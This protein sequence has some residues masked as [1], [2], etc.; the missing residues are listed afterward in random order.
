MDRRDR[1]TEHI[2]LPTAAALVYFGV[3]AKQIAGSLE[4]RGILCD[5]AHALSM[6][7][8]I[9][10]SPPP[11]EM[12]SEIPPAALIGALFDRGAHLLVAPDGTEYRNLTIQRKD[13]EAA[14]L[15]LKQCGF[16]RRW[17]GAEA[18]SADPARGKNVI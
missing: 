15:V 6:L 2:G 14:I 1:S 10:V 16:E 5:V 17:H 9:Y 12:P 4:A 3:T 13:M 18:P 8:P 11:P 7:A